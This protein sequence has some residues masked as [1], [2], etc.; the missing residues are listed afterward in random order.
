[1]TFDDAGRRIRSWNRLPDT[2]QRHR[3]EY[4]ARAGT[5]V[6]S[7]PIHLEQITRIG[8]VDEDTDRAAAI[9]ARR[10]RVAFDLPTRFVCQRP[11]GISRLR[12]FSLNG[13][14]GEE[15]FS[16]KNT[17]EQRECRKG[18]HESALST[19]LGASFTW[20]AKLF[21]I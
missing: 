16:R 13:I 7:H 2:W 9:H 6:P 10:G 11:L 14:R 17:D 4:A 5:A 8:G 1:M 19:T 20:N 15:G 21:D 18:P 12:I 3:T